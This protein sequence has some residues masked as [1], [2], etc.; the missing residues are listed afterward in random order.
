[1]ANFN[2][3]PSGQASVDLVLP[4]LAFGVNGTGTWDQPNYAWGGGSTVTLTLGGGT[5]T[6]NLLTPA[7]LLGKNA[8]VST[9]GA[10]G[11][12]TLRDQLAAKRA[13]AW[14]SPPA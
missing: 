8:S 14:P 3:T 13:S 4:S 1:M 10:N 7:A 2:Q 11:M 12:W 9:S 6:T 5:T